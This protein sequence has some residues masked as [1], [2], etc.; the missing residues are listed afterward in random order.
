VRVRGHDSNQGTLSEWRGLI[1]TTGR[2]PGTLMARITH[3][4]RIRADVRAT[5]DV[6]HDPPQFAL[7]IGDMVGTRLAW[8][9]S[10]MHVVMNGQTRITTTWSGVHGYREIP[11]NRMLP[12]IVNAV[13]SLTLNLPIADD[14][15]CTITVVS[16]G[17]GGRETN[18][19]QLDLQP[20]LAP[21]HNL[22]VVLGEN[23]E[24][25]GRSIPPVAIS[26]GTTQLSLP[27]I[28]NNFPPNPNEGR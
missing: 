12:P 6:I 28:V 20:F 5:R 26:H 25:L 19:S 16:E 9:C 1:N 22:E 24:M 3:D 13:P 7:G 11:E 4:V 23:Y 17:P 15:E 27:T 14:D 21:F 8:A 2:G 10:G 18:T